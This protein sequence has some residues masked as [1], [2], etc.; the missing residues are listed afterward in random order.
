MMV[1]VG[2][3]C[4]GSGIGQSVV[5]AVRLCGDSYRLIGFDLNPFAHGG[6]F[7]D[8]FYKTKPIEESGYVDRLLDT[9][10]R[11]KIKVIIPGLDNDLLLLSQKKKYFEEQDVHVLVSPESVTELCLD[12][13]KLSQELNFH[14]PEVVVSYSREEAEEAVKKDRI[15]FPL[16][17]KP[18]TGAG[19]VGIRI[20]QNS[21]ELRLI[22]DNQIIQ[23]IVSVEKSDPDY[24]HFLQGIKEGEVIQVAEVSVQYF[25]S[26]NGKV[27]GRI[28]TRN[29]LK[30]GV[31][32][33]VIPV[34]S[35]L[36]WQSTQRVVE[37]L[38]SLGAWGPINIQGRA[39]SK[40]FHIFEINPRFTGLTGLRAK[41]GFNEVEA[42]LL[43][44]LGASPSRIK[45]S[46]EYNQCHFGVRQINDAK[47]FVGLNPSVTE[48]IKSRASSF[49]EYHGK[50]ILLTGATGYIGQNLLR[51]LIET[52]EIKRVM[53]VVRNKQKAKSVFGP[54]ESEKISFLYCEEAPVKN[55]NLGQVDAIIHLG[56]A[57]PP[58]GEAAIAESLEFTK[59]LVM[60]A[61][62]FQVTEFIYVSSQAVYGEKTRLIPWKESSTPSPN[63]PYAMAK[64]AGER[65]VL[66]LIRLLPQSQVCIL[67]LSRVYGIGGGIRWH[68]MPHKLVS[69]VEK[70]NEMSILG[71]DQVFDLIHIEDVT[72]GILSVL[73]A[74]H[75]HNSFVYNLG[76][77]HSVTLKELADCINRA[78]ETIGFNRVPIRLMPGE[79]E[80]KF[81]LDSTLFCRDF[82]WKHEVSLEVGIRKLV[83][84]R[85]KMETSCDT[86]NRILQ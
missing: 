74:K 49:S 16:I 86:R 60:Q 9:C 81:G 17:A 10:R 56:E 73:K 48:Y 46:L 57:R 44:C 50:V 71:G 77:G 7:C 14:F 22:P 65:L 35:P 59:N 67:R 19:S 54:V 37:H 80:R 82:D 64:F 72:S 23:P 66:G 45:R 41:M 38:I 2:I 31:P 12:K 33:E 1:S 36:I 75:H 20:V 39:D 15:R 61:T 26:K 52:P 47:F 62:A 4:V 18:R 55:W 8:A 83:N 11:E 34:D 63:S 28:A 3:T 85:N 29:K 27:M 84:M 51:K 6:L 78:V 13:K 70:K 53:A 69:D 79:D 5:D 76:G 30:M 25:I 58:E 68:E 42:S 40:G 32:I 21:D 24:S 43:D